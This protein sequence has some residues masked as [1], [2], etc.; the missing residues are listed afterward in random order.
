LKDKAGMINEHDRRLV[1]L[2]T[3]IEEL[4]GTVFPEKLSPKQEA[5]KAEQ[6]ARKIV[7]EHNK[8]DTPQQLNGVRG[9]EKLTGVN[10]HN[11]V[12]PPSELQEQQ[13]AE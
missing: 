8:K 7:H 5:R 9:L 4:E 2:L 3:R 11:H 1:R 10:G 6:E 12:E 13:A